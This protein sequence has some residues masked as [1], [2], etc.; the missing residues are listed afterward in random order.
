MTIHTNK[1]IDT[2]QV[3][4]GGGDQVSR[5]WTYG[6]YIYQDMALGSSKISAGASMF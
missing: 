4:I 2:E 6:G 1:T 5:V 3:M